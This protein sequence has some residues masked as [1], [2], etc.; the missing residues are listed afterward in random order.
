MALWKCEGCGCG[1][2]AS[3]PYLVRAMGWRVDRREIGS[4]RPAVWPR[5]VAPR[6]ARFDVVDTGRDHGVRPLTAVS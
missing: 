1:V 5:C 6:N 2:E 3:S 4:V